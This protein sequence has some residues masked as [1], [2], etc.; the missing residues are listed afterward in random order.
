VSVLVKGE[1]LAS[2]DAV[3]EALE[4][5]GLRVIGVSGTVGVITGTADDPDRLAALK[6]LDGVESV[7]VARKIQLPPPDSP[8][9]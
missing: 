4:G 1:H 6:A 5:A 7:E 9:Q 8:I 3:A 2:I